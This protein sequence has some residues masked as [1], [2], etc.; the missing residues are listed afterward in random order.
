[1]LLAG[2]DGVH[3]FEFEDTK[4]GELP[5]GW[6]AATTG[7]GPGSVWKVIEDSTSPH[8]ARAL[9]QTSSEGPSPLFNLCVL[10]EPELAEVDLTVS[11]KAVAG[12]VDQGGGPV[13]RYQDATN[14]Y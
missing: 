14:Y 11:L 8:G 4:T 9:A 12:K 3:K 1:M 5:P 10:D 6:S 2:A 13:W 7:E